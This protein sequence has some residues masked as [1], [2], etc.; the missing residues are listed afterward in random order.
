MGRVGGLDLMVTPPMPRHRGRG[1]SSPIPPPYSS[2][3][4][5][6]L[7]SLLLRQFRLT[8]TRRALSRDTKRFAG[9]HE[10]LRSARPS[11][12]APPPDRQASC[13]ARRVRVCFA[14]CADKRGTT[15]CSHDVSWHLKFF[16]YSISI[17]LHE[18]SFPRH[19]AREA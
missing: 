17:R 1:C 2:S 5:C 12:C 9:I 6:H 7:P 14:A 13:G 19:R 3:S 10:T 16:Q 8:H 15:S 11:V 4:G 18:N